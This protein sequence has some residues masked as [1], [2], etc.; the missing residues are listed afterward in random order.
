MTFPELLAAGFAGVPG[1]VIG[2]GA[3]RGE[4]VCTHP[5]GGSPAFYEFSCTACEVAVDL[6][7]GELTVLKHISVADVGK[8][9]NPAQ[10]ESQDEGAA[11][12]GLGHT[13]MERLVLDERGR[14]LN[15]GALD[16]RVPTTKDMPAELHSVLIENGDGPGPYG[17]KGAG[18]GGL[19]G[20]APAIA[21]A[22]TEAT[23]AVIR[24]LPLTPERIWAAMQPLD[25]SEPMPELDH[26]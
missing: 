5:L 1:E 15:L 11:V 13:L 26:R 12:M 17:S 8:A 18:E 16:Y 4:S 21:S 23:G 20:V 19:F 3:C 2:V 25:P 14:I 10:T 6:E 9:L 7:T 24:D 22:V